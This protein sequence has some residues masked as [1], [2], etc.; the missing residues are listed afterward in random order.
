LLTKIKKLFAYIRVSTVK[1]GEKGV[2]LQEQRDSILRY[3][4]QCGIEIIQWFE[5][6]ETAAKRGRPV[7]NQMLKLLKQGKSDGV[8]IH[9]VDRSARNLKDWADLGELIDGGIE[10]HFANES[11]D[12]NSR[13]GRLSADIQAVIAAD[14]IRN[15]REEVKKGFYGRLKQGLYPLPAPLGYLD[16]GKGKPKELDPARAPLVKKAFELYAT[17]SYNLDRLGDEMWHL[18]LRNRK[19]GRVSLNGLSIM[20][21]NPFYIGVIRIEKTNETFAGIHEP[22]VS[23]SLFDRVRLVLNGKTNARSI[24]HEFLFR[25]LLA[26]KHCG[27]SLIGEIQKGYVYYRC[28]TKNCPVTSVREDIVDMEI[29]GTLFPLQLTEAEEA[30]ARSRL[31]N[32]DDAWKRERDN[33]VTALTLNLARLQDRLSRLTDAFI[34]GAIEKDI[35]EEKKASLL[36]ERK[37]IEERLA[38]LKDKNGS[39][40]DI[41]NDFLELAKSAY[42]SYEMDFPDEKRDL[43]KKLT[44]NRVVDGKNADFTLAIPFNEIANR[45]NNSNSAPYRGIP[46][47]KK[48]IKRVWDPLLR[49]LLKHFNSQKGAAENGT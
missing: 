34:D 3:A 2:S 27:Y 40:P 26:C 45:F 6:K 22:L 24:K 30:Y 44:S 17:G 10:V 7:F 25:R 47:T 9:K 41:L 16:R 29:R 13:G 12:L 36:I 33:T 11:L 15:L 35:F 42:L 1:Q 28:H 4:Q 43:V 19:G 38:A 32:L 49:K 14:Y 31:A 46:R 5:E 8:I 37:S 48:Q 21:N 20:L 23:K 39:A 18:G